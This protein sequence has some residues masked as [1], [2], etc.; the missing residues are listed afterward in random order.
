MIPNKDA[1]PLLGKAA[2]WFFL[3]DEDYYQAIG[4][5]EEAYRFKTETTRFSHSQPVVLVLAFQVP[6]WIYSRLFVLERSHD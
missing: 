4:D 1:L 6:P 2:L 5:F 3:D